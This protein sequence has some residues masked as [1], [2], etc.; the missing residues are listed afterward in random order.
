MRRKNQNHQN[1]IVIHDKSQ[2]NDQKFE[3][4]IS[5]QS[6]IQKQEHNLDFDK[7]TICFVKKQY[8]NFFFVLQLCN[9]EFF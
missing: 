2:P 5:A 7:S 4:L 1:H 9:S 8:Y 6:K 3:I